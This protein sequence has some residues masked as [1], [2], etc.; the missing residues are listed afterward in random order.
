MS[1]PVGETTSDRIR[2]EKAKGSVIVNFQEAVIASTNDA[3]VLHETGHDPVFYIP[4]DRVEMSFLRPSDHR[5]T[6][7]WKGEA[8]YWSISAV[9]QAAENAVW[10][11]EQPNEGAREIAGY[12]AFDPRAVTMSVANEDNWGSPRI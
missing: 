9:G 5:T 6:C 8:R 11:Y 3:L 2:I 12:M 4:R 1:N 7:P 10:S